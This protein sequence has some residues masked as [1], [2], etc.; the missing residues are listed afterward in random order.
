MGPENRSIINREE[1]SFIASWILETMPNPRWQY[2]GVSLEPFHPSVP[3][4]D[5]TAAPE[6]MGDRRT[7][8]P[9]DTGFL[10]G[11]QRCVD[12]WERF[13]PDREPASSH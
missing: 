10:A 1:N 9:V 8:M 13:L 6:D 2:K 3:N 4:P 11:P 7:R 5:K 12:E